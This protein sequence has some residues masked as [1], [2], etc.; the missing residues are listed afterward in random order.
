[1]GYYDSDW[2]RI[3]DDSKNISGYCISFMSVIFSWNSKKWEAVAQSSTK[4]K[5]IT[6]VAASNH[7]ISLRKIFHDLGYN[8]KGG[9]MLFIDNQSVMS[10]AKNLVQH[11]R[12]KHIRIKF[13]SIKDAIKEEEIWFNIM[14]PMSRLQT[15][16]LKVQEKKI[17]FY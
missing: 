9:P 6:I 11:G 8:H 3:I 1:M 10:I 13:H 16:L 5:Y 14:A 17:L 7:A 15:F 12:T 2:A 4:V